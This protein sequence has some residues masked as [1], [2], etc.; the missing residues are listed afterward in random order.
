MKPYLLYILFVLALG[1]M[2]ALVV[3]V[4]GEDQEEIPL[5]AAVETDL[6]ELPETFAVL[7]ETF[8]EPIADSDI[9]RIKKLASDPELDEANVHALGTI[10]VIFKG[11]PTTL[12]LETEVDREDGTYLYLY[13]F[14]EPDI[15]EALDERIMAYY[16]EL[17]I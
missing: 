10:D 15:V 3:N 13:L 11:R 9:A 8:D 2:V 1:S 7:S 4:F 5:A 6:E 14:G 16:E 12:T 17:G